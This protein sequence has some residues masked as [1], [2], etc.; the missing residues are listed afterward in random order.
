MP[1]L[2][3][4]ADTSLSADLIQRLAGATNHMLL[5]MREELNALFAIPT[6]IHRETQDS[7]LSSAAAIPGNTVGRIVPQ[8]RYATRP[9][10]NALRPNGFRFVLETT[11]NYDVPYAALRQRFLDATRQGQSIAVARSTSGPRARGAGRA[12]CRAATP[13]LV[14]ERRADRHHHGQQSG[15]YPVRAPVLDDHR[16]APKRL[17]QSFHVPRS[18]RLANPNAYVRALREGT[19]GALAALGPTIAML[20]ETSHVTGCMTGSSPNLCSI[21]SSRDQA[22]SATTSD[23]DRALRDPSLDRTGKRVSGPPR[24]RRHSW[25]RRPHQPLSHPLRAASEPKPDA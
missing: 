2:A 23:I 12:Q 25:Q 21:I 11:G 4:E 5:Q 14:P 15:Q 6:S 24:P 16:E 3:F 10:Q 18:E 8:V 22:E 13:V 9:I 17:L 7:F 19:P 1:G 20:H